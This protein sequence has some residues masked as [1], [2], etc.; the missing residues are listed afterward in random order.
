MQ[1]YFSEASTKALA[2][3]TGLH[4][5]RN[6][7][8]VHTAKLELQE[9][10]AHHNEQLSQ[11]YYDY[12]E[13]TLCY[14]QD[15]HHKALELYEN[16][17]AKIHKE[18]E[19][20]LYP[21]VCIYLGTIYSRLGQSFL[22][23]HYFT[24]A[25]K[26]LT[27]QDPKL[28]LFLNVN[29]G[30]IYLQ[31]GQWD[32]AL[33]HSQ[34][35]I[36]AGKNSDNLDTYALAWINSGLAY[37][38]LG[39]FDAAQHALDYAVG[40]TKKHKLMHAHSCALLYYAKWQELKG[41]NKQSNESY[42]KA[43]VYIKKYGDSFIQI[44]FFES[45]AQFL[46]GLRQYHHAIKFCYQIFKSPQLQ[47]NN[48]SLVKLYSV[49]A[50][51]HHAMK[52]YEEENRFLRL[53]QEKQNQELVTRKKNEVEYIDKV[54][55]YTEIENRYKQSL[56]IQ[57][58]LS[59]LRK[60]G[61]LITNTRGSES[62]FLRIFNAINKLIP[63]SAFCL[64]FYH[65]QRNELEYRYLVEE[66]KFYPP[67]IQDCNTV[68]RMGVY[69]L[70]SKQTIRLA[71]SSPQE[72]SQYLDSDTWQDSIWLNNEEDRLQGTSAIWAP[73]IF[74]DK[75]LGVMSVQMNRSNDYTQVHEQLVEQIASYLAVAIS[76]DGQRR[77]LENHNVYLE[78]IYHTDHL[79]G[80][81]NHYGFV[82]WLNESFQAKNIPNIGL[83][84]NLDGFKPFNRKYSRQHGDDALAS[85]AKL[86]RD[87]I[88]EHLQVFRLHADEFLII[89]KVDESAEATSYAQTIHHNIKQHFMATLGGGVQKILSCTIGITHLR[90]LE[91]VVECE[92]KLSELDNHMQLVKQQRNDGVFII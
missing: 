39:D 82:Q 89:G 60:L 46:K 34:R 26:N 76:H 91:D 17:L 19:Y 77:E 38:N 80:L 35:A 50:D 51:C 10:G 70:K 9:I 12:L 87:L 2:V 85:C 54:I 88:P 4:G 1:I 25:E 21:Y 83:L 45:Y 16:V 56:L 41:N 36:E 59:D 61:Q 15:K 63:S 43:F 14:R 29:L 7:V 47:A 33:A 3:L 8:G 64:A 78:Q 13:A 6:V 32:R 42:N 73:V 37:A 86:I 48:N 53:I 22:S 18:E 31:L 11:V 27:Q 74:Q 81:K 23:Q 49:V 90:D 72:L 52:N 58:R 75:V 69:C 28:L 44:E 62:E 92:N 24:L 67:F 57:D 5:D 40:F 55:S 66:G 30:D 79:T 71:T 68:S 84:L 65:E 20:V